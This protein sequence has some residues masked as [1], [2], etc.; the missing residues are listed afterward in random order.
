[1]L[2][3]VFKPLDFV[4]VL[5]GNTF[6]SFRPGML[7]WT[8]V[9]AVVC[10]HGTCVSIQRNRDAPFVERIG[11]RTFVVYSCS[12]RLGVSYC[13]RRETYVDW[14][15][16]ETCGRARGKSRCRKKSGGYEEPKREYESNIDRPFI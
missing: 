14:D 8:I 2:C 11:A 9:I 1:M 16:R 15:V 6:E 7:T 4:P 10:A 13:T 5:T 3:S 12:N